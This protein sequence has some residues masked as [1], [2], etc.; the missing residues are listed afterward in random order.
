MSISVKS[1]ERAE[2]ER[3]IVASDLPPDHVHIFI[4]CFRSTTQYWI[5]RCGDEVICIYGIVPPTLASDNAYL[6]LYTTPALEGNEFLFV[7]HSQRCAEEILKLYPRIVGHATVGADRSIRWL[8]WLG[9]KFGE[10]Q[11][12]LIPF[13]IRMKKWRTR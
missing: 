11:G 13:T 4:Q 1:A 7:R 3:F 5:G 12:G 10:P 2:V 6:W 9:A 8:R